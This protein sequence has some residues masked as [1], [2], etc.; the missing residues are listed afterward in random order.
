MTGSEIPEPRGGHIG[1]PLALLGFALCVALYFIQYAL[2]SAP[3]VM[4]GA[5]AHAFDVSPIEIGGLSSSFFYSYAIFAL[6]SGAA[7]D[8]FGARAPL[9]IGAAILAVGA[10]LFVLDGYAT[11]QLGRLLQGAGGA[12]AF[13]GAVY[14]AAGGVAPSRLALAI[15][16]A[17]GVGMLGAWAGEVIVSTAL[18]LWGVPW[19]ALWIVAACA[20]GVIALAMPRVLPGP[21]RPAEDKP[22]NILRPYRILIA[23]PRNWLCAICS[24][25]LF[26]PTTIGAL[27]WRVPF[28]TRGLDIGYQHAVL[29]A[30]MVPLGWVLGAPL[31]GWISDRIGRRKPVLIWGGLI[32]AAMEGLVLFAP[33]PVAA[34]WA[35]DFVFGVVSGAAMVPYTIIKEINPDSVKGSAVGAMNLIVFSISAFV[36]TLHIWILAP[37]TAGSVLTAAALRQVGLLGFSG[38]IIAILIATLLPETGSAAAALPLKRPQA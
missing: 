4:S 38:I 33:T 2:R 26:V 14:V 16:V 9:P 29:S 30:S 10:L 1:S 19:Q 17:Q 8:R 31:L 21:A 34:D 24:G 3:P 13:T 37:N 23:N 15:G 25:C 36:G 11:A 18:R 28:Y 12:F 6:V 27:T 22:S 7:L 20:A 32:L 35:V 5:L